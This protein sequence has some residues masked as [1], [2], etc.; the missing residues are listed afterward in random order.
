MEMKLDLLP[1]DCIAHVLS[2]TTPQDVCQSSIVSSAVRRA[3]E[4]D[5]LWEKFLPSDYRE[6]IS[7]LMFPVSFTSKKELFVKLSSPLL[8]DGGSK[9]F[10][11]DKVTGKKSYML[12]AREL[13]ITWSSNSLYWSW[14]PLLKSRFAEVTEL[15]MVCWLEISAKMN[16]QML[17]PNTNYGAYLV[18][19]FAR[20]AF[21][22]DS[23][24][25]DVSVEVGDYKSRGT[26]YL[27]QNGSPEGV[28]YRGDGWTEI[29]LG[30]FYSDGNDKE[31]KMSLREVKG[32]HLKGGLIV[33]G[34]EI[35]PK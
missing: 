15:V 13:H 24:P 32:E 17:S 7:R 18:V 31:M 16:T 8:I 35:R 22:L 11:I 25:S 20:R 23:I 21:G 28:F 33:E 6:I 2:C 5:N 29:E 26:I 30:S 9:T 4:S 10:S 34:I 14:K 27:R 3:A 19:K 1:D 12:S